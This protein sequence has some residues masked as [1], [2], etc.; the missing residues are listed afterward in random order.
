MV[1]FVFGW[2]LPSSI[3]VS[4]RNKKWVWPWARGALQNFGV[5]L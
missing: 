3:I 4:H 5:P 1:S 2:G